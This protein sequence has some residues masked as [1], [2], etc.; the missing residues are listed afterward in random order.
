M[1]PPYDLTFIVTTLAGIISS[2]LTFTVLLFLTCLYFTLLFF[3]L[4]L[5]SN[6][7]TV[8]AHNVPSPLGFV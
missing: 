8:F 7:T 2:T 1:L 3:A 4:G 5:L 6:S